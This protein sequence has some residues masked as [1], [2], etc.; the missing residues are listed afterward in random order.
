L[1][2]QLQTALRNAADAESLKQDAVKKSIDTEQLYQAERLRR[3]E[4]DTLQQV[5]AEE[6]RSLKEVANDLRVSLA[7]Q[8]QGR[9]EA[10][11]RFSQDLAQERM[12]RQKEADQFHSEIN[13]AKMQIEAARQAEREVREQVK[14]ERGQK[15]GELSS[16]RQRANSASDAL[17]ALRLD[18]AELKGQYAGMVMRCDQL[19]GRLKEQVRP[20]V[21]PAPVKTMGSWQGKRRL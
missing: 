5:Q 16:Y 1:Q 11:L 9:A 19:Q 20:R 14:V 13:F 10:Q 6:I 8:E 12:A 21:R 17:A 18:Y 2:E 3:E 7:Q 15:E 4:L